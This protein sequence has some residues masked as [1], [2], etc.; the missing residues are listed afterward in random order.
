[1]CKQINFFLALYLPGRDFAE[2]E[3]G[4]W[5]A[6]KSV[7]KWVASLEQ[8]LLKRFPQRHLDGW[9]SAGDYDT[10]NIFS[11]AGYELSG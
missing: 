11:Q 7:F 3:S 5:A 9:G 2:Q 10:L 8:M 1:M 6:L 4:F